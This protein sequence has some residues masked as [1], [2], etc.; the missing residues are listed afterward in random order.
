MFR[1]QSLYDFY[2]P[3]LN[4]IQHLAHKVMELLPQELW[5]VG[6]GLMK[7]TCA[8]YECRRHVLAEDYVIIS[9]YFSKRPNIFPGT[10]N[11][12]TMTQ[13]RPLD[14]LSDLAWV[15]FVVMTN[16]PI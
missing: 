1:H 2:L 13:I 9:L 4:Y 14:I 12:F 3:L 6:Q 8:V 16:S 11:L 10:L 7:H 15:R 5:G